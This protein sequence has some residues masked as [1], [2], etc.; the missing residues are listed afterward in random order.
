MC[1]GAGNYNGVLS[2]DCMPVFYAFTSKAEVR[3]QRDVAVVI[4]ISVRY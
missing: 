4:I 3:I 2:V 1:I